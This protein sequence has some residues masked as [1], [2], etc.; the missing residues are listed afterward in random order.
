MVLF[1]KFMRRIVVCSTCKFS[2]ESKFAP[3][4]RT[5]GEVLAQHLMA[6]ARPDV[7]V[8]TQ[9]CLWNCAKPCSVAIHD[10]ERF[11]YFTGGHEPSSEQAEAILQWFDQHG[12]SESGEVPFREW[13]QR[14]RGHF[15][16]RIPP[17]KA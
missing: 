1:V 2:T 7:N 8:T 16:A 11:S 4:G 17:V 10:D 13:P 15:V 14:M 5:G 9:A 6:A 3:D 12:A